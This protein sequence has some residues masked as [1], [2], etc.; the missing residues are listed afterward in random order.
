MR[1]DPTTFGNKLEIYLLTDLQ[2][3]FHWWQFILLR[4]KI[5]CLNNTFEERNQPCLLKNGI[6]VIR[7]CEL[8]FR[9]TTSTMSPKFK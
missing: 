8:M 9:E 6:F 1:Q 3:R 4:H 7:L 5:K 2:Y